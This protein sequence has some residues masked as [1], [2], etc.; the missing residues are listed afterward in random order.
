MR[1]VWPAKPLYKCAKSRH[2]TLL[3]KQK[4]VADHNIS[5]TICDNILVPTKAQL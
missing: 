1:N 3:P 2:V 5:Q 4:E